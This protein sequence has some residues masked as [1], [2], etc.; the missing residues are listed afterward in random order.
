MPQFSWVPPAPKPPGLFVTTAPSN[1]K[2]KDHV[3]VVVVVAVG[4]ENDMMNE[5]SEI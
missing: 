4:D 5:W 1:S 3:T 2:Q